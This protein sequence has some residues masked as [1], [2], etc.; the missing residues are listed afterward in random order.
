MSEPQPVLAGQVITLADAMPIPARPAAGDGRDPFA[1]ARDDSQGDDGGGRR[2]DGAAPPA[3]LPDDCP[4][5]P[6]G[7]SADGKLFFYLDPGGRLQVMAQ[8]DHSRLGILG[9][10]N[11]RHSVLKDYWPRLKKI[12]DKQTGEVEWSVEGWRPELAAEELFGACGRKGTINPAERVRGPGAWKGREDELILHCGD[13]ILCGGAIL[14]PGDIAGYIYPANAPIPQPSEAFAPGG[15]SGPAAWVLSLFRCW[16]WRRPDVDAHLLLGM[17]GAAKIGGALPWRPVAWITGEFGAGKST[18]MTFFAGLC[19]EGG[20]HK[21]AETSAAGIWQ[22]T[23]QS[24]LPIVIDEAEP[25]TDPRK[26]SAVLRLARIA[27]SGDV[28]FRG[29]DNHNPVKFVIQCCF[30][31]GSILVPPLTPQDRSRI[32]VLEMDELTGGKPPEATPAKLKA[33]GEA[34]TRR[35]V[36]GWP[37]LAT[38]FDAYRGAL[39]EHGHTTRSADQFGVLLAC[40]H[41]LLHDDATPE[42]DYLDYWCEQLPP[43]REIHRDWRNAAAWLMTQPMEPPFRGGP[44]KTVSQWCR[45]GLNGDSDQPETAN[46]ALE[47]Y[48]LKIEIEKLPMGGGN[49]GWLYVANSHRG[50][51]QLFDGSHWSGQSG[52]SNP[53]VQAFHRL[54]E[55]AGVGEARAWRRFAGYGARCTKLPAL[56]VLDGEGQGDAE[57]APPL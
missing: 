16:Q 15:P 13:R 55:A 25:D 46:H 7:M 32:A 3:G 53:W 2:R 52:T 20:L 47:T 5:I 41:L 51:T 56:Y 38:V 24:T 44:R 1:K 36:D 54:A 11:E 27:S 31:F 34:L 12:T 33:A 45:D 21:T 43:D 35:M 4:V 9:L 57:G 49:F 28:V 39:I 37:R 22:T 29:G 48:G 50:L 26:M 18:L 8:R 17:L 42:A 6:L 14:K 40:A 19:G 23:R 10:F 30:L